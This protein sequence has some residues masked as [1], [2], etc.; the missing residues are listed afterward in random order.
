MHVGKIINLL[1]EVYLLFI[2]YTVITVYSRYT[3]RQRVVDNAC[4]LR[5]GV[6]FLYKWAGHVHHSN[7]VVHV[8]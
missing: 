3:V 8:V 2:F 6:V 1:N 7:V 4:R 5:G